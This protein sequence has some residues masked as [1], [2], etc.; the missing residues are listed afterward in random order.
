[1]AVQKIYFDTRV[2]I[3]FVN[4]IKQS[5][6]YSGDLVVPKKLF[7]TWL[8]AIQPLY[9]ILFAIFILH[10]RESELYRYT[11]DG[12]SALAWEL[13]FAMCLGHLSSTKK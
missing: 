13:P 3:K 9:F 8:K 12:T 11:L 2:I 10:S 4:G 6:L 7:T 5:F 1:M